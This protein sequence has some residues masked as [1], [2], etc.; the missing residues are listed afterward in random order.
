MLP[1]A[2][3]SQSRPSTYHPPT[4]PNQKPA[5]GHHCQAQAP[6]E[7][8][9][10][11]PDTSSRLAPSCC[12]PQWSPSLRWTGV[13]ARVIVAKPRPR[14]SSSD[15]I[16]QDLPPRVN[17]APRSKAP[18]RKETSK[19]RHKSKRDAFRKRV[20]P[21]ASPSHGF[22]PLMKELEGNMM[23]S[24]GKAAWRVPAAA[25]LGSCPDFW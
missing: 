8:Q 24:T 3:T 6:R 4:A 14:R 1:A 7:E 20:T 15:F 10:R 9:L 16:L 21:M 13:S 22:H 17:Q 19:P 12:N 5:T 25:P 23:P 2:P 11:L 18:S